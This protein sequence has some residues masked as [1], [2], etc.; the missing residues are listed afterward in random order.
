MQMSPMEP[1]AP[2][3]SVMA[4]PGEGAAAD[5]GEGVVADYRQQARAF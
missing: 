4:D 2:G 5:R 3:E 1:Y